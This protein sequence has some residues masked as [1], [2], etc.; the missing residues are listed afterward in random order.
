MLTPEDEQEIREWQKNWM[1]DL[2]AKIKRTNMINWSLQ[3]LLNEIDRL[4]NEVSLLR[5]TISKLPSPHGTE[6]GNE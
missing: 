2:P 5:E 1:K 4:R 3:A 6:T